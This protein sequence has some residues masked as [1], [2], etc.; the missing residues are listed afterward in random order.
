MHPINMLLYFSM[1]GISVLFFILI[2]AFIRTGGFQAEGIQMPKFFTIGTFLLFFSSYTI[3]KVP[4]IYKKDKLNKM[5]RYLGMTLLLGLLFIGAQLIGWREISASGFSFT[6]KVSGTYFYL[7]SA[8]HILHLL[9]GLI[10]L[11]FLFFKTSHVAAD[12]IRTLV[13]IRDPY[14]RLQLAMVGRYWHFMN[15]L[16][17]GLFIVFLFMI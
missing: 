4:G 2:I 13:F 1:A 7:I 10:F 14:R 8:L 6:G 11:S 12:E 15:F 17:L 16:W 9:G 3:S 5:I